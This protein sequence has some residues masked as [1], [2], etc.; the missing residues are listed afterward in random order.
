MCFTLLF[1]HSYCPLPMIEIIIVPIVETNVETY[2]IA[3]TDQL[4]MQP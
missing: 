1:T 3:I 4:H 2:V